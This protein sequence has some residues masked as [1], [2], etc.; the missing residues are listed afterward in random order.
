VRNENHI[1]VV[2]ERKETT[3]SL[4]QKSCVGVIMLFLGGGDRKDD[5]HLG[6]N[7]NNDNFRRAENIC[8]VEGKE[9]ND[10]FLISWG[11]QC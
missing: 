1:C 3:Q 7:Q 4:Q 9:D 10:K 2:S 5:S 6:A 8:S 11:P